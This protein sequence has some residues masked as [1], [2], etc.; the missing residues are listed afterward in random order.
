MSVGEICNREVI[1][2]E[3]KTGVQEAAKLMR[4]YHVGDVVVV[5]RSDGET[6]PAGVL[7]DR[8][9]VVEIVA[10]ELSPGSVYVEDVM[11]IDAVTVREDQGVWETIQC[12]RNNGIR[13]IIVVNDKGSLV[14]ILA[15]DDLLEL[16]SE[17]MS[18]FAKLFAR[19]QIREREMRT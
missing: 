1:V 5:D 9:I 3:R 15:I 6:V 19:E 4:Q 16:L 11:S 10:K 8:D 7:T 13:R 18:E 14:G 12:M 2:V 17:E